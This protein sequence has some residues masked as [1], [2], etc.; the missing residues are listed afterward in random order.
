MH[1]LGM[2]ET[3]QVPVRRSDASHG[4]KGELHQAG[5]ARTAG[6]ARCPAATTGSRVPQGRQLLHGWCGGCCALVAVVMCCADGGRAGAVLDEE[7][8]R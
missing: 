8:Q 6:S 1:L 4:K 2:A 3:L 5:R 7:R